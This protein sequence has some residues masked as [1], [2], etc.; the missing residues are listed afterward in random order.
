[1]D[2]DYRNLASR[3]RT[4]REVIEQ[5]AIS[6]GTRERLRSGLYFKRLPWITRVVFLAPPHRGSRLADWG[7]VRLVL[8][9]I[10]FTGETAQLATEIL[11]L[12]ENTINP[13][14]RNFNTLGGRSVQ[15]L[16][17]RHPYFQA[18]EARPILVPNHSVIGDRG[19]GDSPDSSDGVVP[20]WSA[21]LAGA[22]SEK[23]VPAGHNLTRNA[24]TVEEVRRILLE[25]LRKVESGRRVKPKRAKIR[26]ETTAR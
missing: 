3:V 20:Y 15:T 1:M 17:P 11:T 25:H 2:L 6:D 23:I 16:S 13:D 14:L 24:M 9:F 10:R 26:I 4:P 19:R 5:L 8:T 22:Q 12:E 7:I 21:H 18:L